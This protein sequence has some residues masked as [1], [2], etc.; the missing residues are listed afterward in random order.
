MY[1]LYELTWLWRTGEIAHNAVFCDEAGQWRPV[2]ELVEPALEAQRAATE[3]ASKAASHR[4]HSPV[5]WWSVA[6]G[7]ALA[8]GAVV[9]PRVWREYA[10]WKT[11]RLAER[12]ALE[13]ERAARIEDF[14]ASNL[15]V[16]GMTREDVRRTIGPP[17]AINTS[18]DGGIERWVYRKQIVVIENGKVIG[19]EDLKK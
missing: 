6:L 4:W 16:P 14:V 1:E 8:V 2:S 5:L 3:P 11:R 18:G 7:L 10:A 12:E 19:F 15:V 17:R 9:G 13:R